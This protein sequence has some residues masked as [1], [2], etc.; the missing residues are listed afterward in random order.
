MK[1][2]YNILKKKNRSF[3]MCVDY[4]GFNKVIVKNHYP[5]PLIFWKTWSIK[6]IDK[7]WIEMCL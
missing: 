6:S 7:N 5:L 4:R 1:N 3:H 2:A